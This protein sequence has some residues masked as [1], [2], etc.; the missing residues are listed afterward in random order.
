MEKENK[1]YVYLH[2]KLTNGEPFYVGKGIGKRKSSKTDRNRWWNFIVNKHGYDIIILEENLSEEKAIEREIYWIDRIGKASENKG[3][4]VNI[5]NGGEGVSGYKHTDET[6]KRITETLLGHKRN[7]GK[8]LTEEHKKNIS[9]SKKGQNAGRI[10]SPESLKKTS[11]KLKGI[12]IESIIVLDIETGVYYYSIKE[13]SRIYGEDYRPL[14]RKLKLD[15]HP[16]LK[17]T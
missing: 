10:N 12:K 13:V 16:R 4:L 15:R 5:T 14:K 11:D 6:K 1:Y 7:S 9:L 2:V 8:I 17:I 3:T